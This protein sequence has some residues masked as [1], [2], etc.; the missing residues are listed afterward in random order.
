MPAELGGGGFPQ[1][2]TSLFTIYV[3]LPGLLDTEIRDYIISGGVGNRRKT[4]EKIQRTWVRQWI[5]E[6][7]VRPPATSG[8]QR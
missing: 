6:T 5:A 2:L 1:F 8:Q 4:Q 7:A 3:P